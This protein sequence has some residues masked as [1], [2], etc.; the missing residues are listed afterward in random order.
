M[1]GKWLRGLPVHRGRAYPEDDGRGAWRAAETAQKWRISADAA[2]ICSKVALPGPVLE[3]AFAVDRECM[4]RVPARCDALLGQV[5]VGELVTR[6]VRRHVD[7]VPSIVPTGPLGARLVEHER[8]ER[9]GRLFGLHTDERDRS[10]G[11][12]PQTS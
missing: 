5:R 8:A 11:P 7:R 4:Q 6:K 1:P 2:V 3:D 9:L 12:P 10:A